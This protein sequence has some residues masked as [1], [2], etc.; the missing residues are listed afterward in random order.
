[1]D[2]FTLKFEILTRSTTAESGKN[3]QGATFMYAQ[4]IRE[5][6][7]RMEQNDM[8]TMIRYCRKIYANDPVQL[9]YIDEFEGGYEP[10]KAISWYT[11][12]TFLYKAINK[13]IREQD[14]R[15]LFAMRPFICHLHNQITTRYHTQQEQYKNQLL[16]LYRGQQFPHDEFEK[17]KENNGCLISFS[18]FLSTTKIKELALIYA[19]E[20][21]EELTALI[22]EIELDRTIN[23]MT[24]SYAS[25]ED[26]S[27]FGSGEQE[28][29][30]TMGAV[31]RINNVKKELNGMWCVSLTLTN[32]RDKELHDMTVHL[33]NEL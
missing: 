13:G 18:N 24:S 31:F 8:K 6:F 12:D 14:I 25:I 11:R 15:I 22:F 28:W 10:T 16:T 30:F 2:R 3:K 4:L 7:L 33:R 19:G 5:L 21:D 32:E 20:S 29:L 9:R 27:H 17:I 1:M 26:L 23:E